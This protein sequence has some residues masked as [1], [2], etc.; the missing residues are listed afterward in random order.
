MQMQ[1]STSVSNSLVPID[2]RRIR[3]SYPGIQILCTKCFGKH[4]KS[5]CGSRKALF[6]DYVINFAI[7]NPDYPS[8]IY[9]RWSELIDAAAQLTGANAL[10][11]TGSVLVPTPD[12]NPPTTSVQPQSSEQM[13]ESESQPPRQT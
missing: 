10:P 7:R 1:I 13:D 5:K 2:G 12:S 8:D 4:H 11:V 9:G 6:K 3:I